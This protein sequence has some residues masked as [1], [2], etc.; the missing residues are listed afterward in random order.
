[1]PS[2]CNLKISVEREFTPDWEDLLDSFLSAVTEPGLDAW[3]EEI[4]AIASS[5]DD[6]LNDRKDPQEEERLR[7]KSEIERLQQQLAGLDVSK[8]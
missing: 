3:Q 2:R 7:I 5:L 1:M 8:Q 4:R 6:P